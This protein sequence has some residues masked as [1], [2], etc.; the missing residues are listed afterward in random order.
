[1]P[2]IYVLTARA[3]RP[4]PTR[5]HRKDMVVAGD[6][7]LAGDNQRLQRVR[8]S[9]AHTMGSLSTAAAALN[10]GEPEMTKITSTAEI[11]KCEVKLRD[12]TYSGVPSYIELRSIHSSRCP[13]LRTTRRITWRSRGS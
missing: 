11:P 6:T 5:L 10:A 1:M 12:N 13:A 3:G 9:V 2:Q 4:V 7:D 8:N